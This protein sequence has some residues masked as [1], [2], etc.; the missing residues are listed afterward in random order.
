MTWWSA[1]DQRW[2][3]RATDH[4][5]ETHE[6]TALT[7]EAAQAAAR[8]AGQRRRAGEPSQLRDWRSMRWSKRDQRWVPNVR[9]RFPRLP[10]P[11]AD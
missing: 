10:T 6:G 5:G 7:Q 9:P 4:V 2:H 1:S 11:P 3:W 8:M